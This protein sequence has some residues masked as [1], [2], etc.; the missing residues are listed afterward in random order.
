MKK[1]VSLLLAVSMV[2]VLFTGCTTPEAQQ[3]AAAE[4]E[5]EETEEAEVAEEATEAEDG[6]V[7]MADLKVILLL[8]GNTGD[9]SLMD[10]G[11]NGMKM[12]EEKYGCTIKINE[13]GND[14]TAYEPSLLDAAEGDWDIIIG[15][16]WQMQEPMQKVAPEHPEKKFIIFDAAVDYTVADLS[17]VYS[18]NYKQNEVSF[19]VGYV[20][21]RISETKQ[22]GFVGGMDNVTIADFLL[23]YIDGAQYADENMK[24]S[25]S[26]VGDFVDTTAAKEMTLA[27]YNQGAD[28]VFACAGGAGLGVFDASKEA[29]KYAFG[30]DSDQAIVFAETDPAKAELIVTSGEKR[31]DNSLL[32]AFDKIAA[33][34]IPWGQEEMLGLADNAVGLS[35]NEYYEAIVPEEVRNEVD[36]IAAKIASGEIVVETAFGKETAEITALVD[37]AKPQ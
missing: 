16:G 20:G 32:L 31:V 13:M 8:T 33:G 36:E 6:E 35:V 2:A 27:Q 30:V 4:T 14:A 17:N 3:E 22:I 28:I 5:V 10:S 7:N 9:L 29:G 37:A 23:G 26:Y 1:L 12:I 11:A 25:S 19:L 24:V 18:I 21:G 15:S 34:T